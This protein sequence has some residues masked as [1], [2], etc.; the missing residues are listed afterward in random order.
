MRY[1]TLRRPRAARV[2]S[3]SRRFGTVY[4][5]RAPLRLARNTLLARRNEEKALQR[6]DWLY[7]DPG[8]SG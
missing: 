5:L 8:T 6:F 7:G 2:Q 4:H 1:E 3:L